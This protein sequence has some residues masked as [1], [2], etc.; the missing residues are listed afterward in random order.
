MCGG[1]V[2][3][4]RCFFGISFGVGE[5]G[6]LTVVFCF[7]CFLSCYNHL[8]HFPIFVTSRMYFFVFI[9]SSVSFSHYTIEF[10]S[11]SLINPQL[12]LFLSPF[13]SDGFLINFASFSVL[14]SSLFTL[15]FLCFHP[16]ISQCKS[17]F[18]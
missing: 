3:V 1:T 11:T 9:L 14:F 17:V 12:F 4:E 15:L 13:Q 16:F 2:N 6:R 7:F 10:S 18:R 5:E 8:F